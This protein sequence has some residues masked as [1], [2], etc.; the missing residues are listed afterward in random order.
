VFD[1]FKSNTVLLGSFGRVWSRVAL[2]DVGQFNGV[3]SDLL[4]LL[5]QRLNLGPIGL[6]SCGDGQRKQVPKRIDG[7]MDLGAL[8]RLA[9]S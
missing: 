6:I 8:R 7:D 3:S 4:D 5:G 2:V 9:P 1:D